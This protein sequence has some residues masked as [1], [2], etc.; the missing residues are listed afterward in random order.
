MVKVPTSL[1]FFRVPSRSCAAAVVETIP[2]MQAVKAMLLNC[3]F[4]TLHG[5]G[6]QASIKRSTRCRGVD[7]F[8]EPLYDSVQQWRVH[9]EGRR[10]QHMIAAHAVDRPA[11]R[12]DHQA[13]RHRLALDSRVQLQPGIKRL[14]G[15]AIG[16]Q[17]EALEQTASAHIAHVGMISEPLVEAAREVCALHPHVR[18]QLV[19]AYHPLHGQSRGARN[20]MTHVSVAVL[21]GAR[22]SGNGLENFV[23]QQKRADRRIAPAETL[24]DRHQIRSDPFVLASM[25]LPRAAH[26]AHHLIENEQNAV[27]VADLT[28]A[29]EIARRRRD[30][31]Q[32]G[33]DDRLGDERDDPVGAE[34]GDLGVQLPGQAFAIGLRRLVRAA[35]AIFVRR[36]YMVRLDQERRELPALP[37]P[38]ADRKRSKRGAVIALASCNEVSSLR[39]S[40]F[41]EILPRKFERGL[42]RLRAA[43]DE[44]HVTDAV[45]RVR[46]K[47]IR[48]L[49][50]NLGGEEARMRISELVDLLMHGAEHVRMR[51]PETGNRR[52]PRGIDVFLARGVANGDAVTA[53][54]ARIGMCDSAMKDAGHDRDR[55]F[56]DRAM[57]VSKAASCFSLAAMAASVCEPW[58]AATRAARHSTAAKAGAMVWKNDGVAVG[59]ISVSSASAASGEI[60]LSVTA[61][62]RTPRARE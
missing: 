31:A 50:G 40:A 3:A 20:R 11:H 7:R 26:A 14:L 34:L 60:S 62:M 42:D 8:A 43:A 54:R 30:R 2:I 61:T 41:D 33:A 22:T 21:E 13:A 37:L 32:A 24:G 27:A 15:A 45:R 12:I 16:D 49:L 28:H 36:R 47:I 59:T 17:L 51:V 48:Q 10:Q 19:A 57:N 56:R 18:Q 53:R 25:Q 5:T 4:L 1:T 39:L 46:D 52:A 6:R 38:A 23:L 55:L 58:R 9:D 44:Q 35:A 29:S